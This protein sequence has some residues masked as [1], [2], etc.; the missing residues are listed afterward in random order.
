MLPQVRLHGTHHLQCLF[1]EMIPKT[2]SLIKVSVIPLWSANYANYTSLF[3]E[4]W[5]ATGYSC[6]PGT[7]FPRDKSYL[8]H[9]TMKYDLSNWSEGWILNTALT[10]AS[11]YILW[12]IY[13]NYIPCSPPR[14]AHS[15]SA[16]VGSLFPFHWQKAWASFQ[17]TWT[18]GKSRRSRIPEPGPAGW[19]AGGKTN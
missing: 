19:G 13:G 18:T 4:V 6:Q 15:H 17:L 7:C 16:S 9:Q 8:E 12:F 10:N 3:W 11:P 14:A 1:L 2:K 5:P